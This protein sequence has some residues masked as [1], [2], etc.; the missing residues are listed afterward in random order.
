MP[1]P[2]FSPK[3]IELLA[4][5]SSLICNNPLCGT[6]TVGPSDASGPLKLKL[7]EAAHIRA[8]RRGQAR[9]DESMTDDQRASFDNGIWLCANCHRMVDKNMGTDF[10]VDVLADWKRSHEAVIR[11][12]LHSHRSPLPLLRRFTEEGAIA[13]EAVDILEQHGALFVDLI[14]E[15]DSHVLISIEHLRADLARLPRKVRYDSRLKDLLKDLVNEVRGFMNRTSRFQGN[16]L[17]ELP[18]LR[19]RTGIHLLRLR[20]EFGCKVRG[21]INRII[22]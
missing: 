1:A 8:A 17:S 21:P 14:Y 9:Y 16:V 6:L 18:A 19:S 12:L 4:F 2:D 3:T 10:P 15:V 22:P 7:G 20:D 5:R 11:S 13:Q